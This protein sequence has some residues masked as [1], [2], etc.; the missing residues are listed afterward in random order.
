MTAALSLGTAQ[1]QTQTIS[2]RLQ[3][4]VRLLQMSS[5]EFSAMVEDQLGQNPFL[6]EDPDAEPRS[7][8]AQAEA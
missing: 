6:E 3:Q 8:P 7:A 4:A 2:P 5:L 1:R